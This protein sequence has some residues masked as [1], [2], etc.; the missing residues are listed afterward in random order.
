M[1][2]SKEFS[3]KVYSFMLSPEFGDSVMCWELDNYKVESPSFAVLLDHTLA[4]VW[5]LFHIDGAELYTLNKADVSWSLRFLEAID[6]S[7]V[8]DTTDLDAL[9]DFHRKFLVTRNSLEDEKSL[10]DSS[11]SMYE[12]IGDSGL[13]SSLALDELLNSADVKE[14]MERE[15]KRPK[16]IVASKCTEAEILEHLK[17]LNPTIETLDDVKTMTKPQ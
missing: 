1:A 6:T 10:A 16:T 14:D 8:G 4:V 2:N 17:K 12:S 7:H 5:H 15:A 3:P 13:S 9:I 11:K